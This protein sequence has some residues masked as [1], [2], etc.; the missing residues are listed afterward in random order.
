MHHQVYTHLRGI[1]DHRELR[2]GDRLPGERELCQV[3]GC[4]LVTMRRALDELTREHRVV[5][6]PGRGTF[7]TAQPLNRNLASLDSFTHEMR[8]LGRQP[9]TR[10][11]TASRTKASTDIAEALQL[12]AGAPTIHLERLRLVDEQPLMLE[13]VHLPADRLPGLLDHDLESQSL[14]DIL[15]SHYHIR[16]PHA[17]ET[18]EAVALSTREAELL[19]DKRGRPALLLHLVAFDH[20]GVPVE[21]CRGLMRRERARYHVHAGGSGLGTLRLAKPTET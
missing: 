15:A 2:A 10:L 18:I 6:M 5:R 1:L 13:T 16:L 19:D 20:H 17:D 12:D 4:S 8:D 7:V 3:Y 14:Y 9:A 21:Y 11:L